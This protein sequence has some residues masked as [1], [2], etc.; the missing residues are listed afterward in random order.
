LFKPLDLLDRVDT[1]GADLEES[2]PRA[3]SPPAFKGS[4]RDPPAFGEFEL[5]KALHAFHSALLR[6]NARKGAGTA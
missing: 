3:G 6:L 4:W 2:R 5:I 1:P